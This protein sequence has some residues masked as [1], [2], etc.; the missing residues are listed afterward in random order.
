MTPKPH[1]FVHSPWVG[2][3]GAADAVIAGYCNLPARK[4]E[5][6]LRFTHVSGWATR[7]EIAAVTGAHD[8]HLFPRGKPVRFELRLRN[9]SDQ[10]FTGRA[11]FEVG[12]HAGVAKTQTIELPVRIDGQGQTTLDWR[13]QPAAPLVA[14]AA[15]R[16]QAGEEVIGSRDF[17]FVYDAEHY[18]PPL[19]RPADFQAFWQATLKEMRDRPLDLQVT[20][21]PE[22]SNPHQAVSLVAFTG[23]EG[24][25]IEGWLVEPTAAG[26]YPAMIGARVQ[27]YQWPQPAP[28]ENTDRVWLVL[29]LYRDGLYSSGLAQR[30]TA[31]FRHVYAD[32]VRAFDV[33]LARTRVDP[34][35]IAV[36]G[37][38]RT[39]PAALAAAALEPRLALVDIHVP[40]SAGISWPRRFYEGWGAGGSRGQPADMP[41][42]AWLDLLGYF[43]A[44]NFAPDVKCP[45]ILGL[46]LRDYGLSPAPGIIA[47][48]AYLPGERAIVASPWEGHC[49]PPKFQALQKTAWEG[50]VA[51]R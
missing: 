18:R 48:Y 25:R 6:S 2:R 30:E 12:D 40:T 50:F 35:R 9:H 46:G 41:V 29:K 44:V 3:P 38:S 5:A 19:T 34:R 20:P 43:D 32:H 36:T 15:M 1:L 4:S 51:G 45:V 11:V 27:S 28:E 16:I 10:P 13:M 21:A 22:L 14:R 49:Y 8:D 39:G 31:E 37:A 7:L 26:K 17:V 33:L 47:A 42:E 24:R 23:L